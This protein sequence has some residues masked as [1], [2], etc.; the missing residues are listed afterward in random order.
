M[1]RIRSENS[2]AE[3]AK[4]STV[5]VPSVRRGG[6]FAGGCFNFFRDGLYY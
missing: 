1:A 5:R 6:R 4:R 3:N 2:G